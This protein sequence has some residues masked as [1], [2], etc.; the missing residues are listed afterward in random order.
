VIFEFSGNTDAILFFLLPHVF[1]KKKT[2]RNNKG[3][4]IERFSAVESREAFLLQ[5]EVQ[6]LSQNH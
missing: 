4:I 5:V 2:K 1:K 3:R 6:R